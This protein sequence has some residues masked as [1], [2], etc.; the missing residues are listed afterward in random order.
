MKRRQVVESVNGFRLHEGTRERCF[1]PIRERQI[2]RHDVNLSQYQVEGCGPG[3]IACGRASLRRASLR[4]VTACG[5]GRCP[6]GP[7]TSGGPRHALCAIGAAA[8][9]AR[10]LRA[11]PP[12]AG[13]SSLGGLPGRLGLALP[14]GGGVAAGVCSRLLQC[15]KLGGRASLVV[16][17]IQVAFRR[18]FKIGPSGRLGRKRPRAPRKRGACAADGTAALPVRKPSTHND[19]STISDNDTPIPPPFPTREGGEGSRIR[20]GGESPAGGQRCGA[21]YGLRAGERPESDCCSVRGRP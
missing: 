7:P 12:R 1:A 3:A 18:R 19:L 15:A 14:S 9:R 10:R 21:G 5:P 13:R 17:S 20:C 4:R 8:S 11:R 2:L 6:V 16:E